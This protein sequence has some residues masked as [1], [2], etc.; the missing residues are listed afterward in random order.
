MRYR[1]LSHSGGQGTI[2]KK[3]P[4]SAPDISAS[5]TFPK[6]PLRWKGPLLGLIGQSHRVLESTTLTHSG[7]HDGPAVGPRRALKDNGND[8]L[9]QCIAPPDS[10]FQFSV[11]LA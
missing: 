5:G 10:P 6:N 4:T 2:H 7:H 11:A 8:P 3:E 1:A 9:A